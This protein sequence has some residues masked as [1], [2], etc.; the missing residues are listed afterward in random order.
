MEVTIN[1]Y[2][3]LFNSKYVEISSVAIIITTEDYVLNNNN[4][5]LRTIIMLIYRKS[6]Y[7][8]YFLN[9]FTNCHRISIQLLS[10][11]GT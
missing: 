1:D 5:A 7:E 6:L 4:S 10:F 3:I 9:M 2:K 8:M 11:L